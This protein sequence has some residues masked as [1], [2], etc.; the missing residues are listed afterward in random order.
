METPLFWLVEFAI[1]DQLGG[2][3]MP[4][5]KLSETWIFFCTE[6]NFNKFFIDTFKYKTFEMSKD[7]KAIFSKF[8]IILSLIYSPLAFIIFIKNFVIFI[9]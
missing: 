4:I 5:E 3:H 6:P 8:K 7:Q 2:T 1:S 9:K